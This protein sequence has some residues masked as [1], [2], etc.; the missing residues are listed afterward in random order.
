MGLGFGIIGCG[1]I[2]KFHAR[3][4]AEVRGAKLLACFDS[5]PA[6]ADRLAAETGCR[7]YHDL[8]AMLADPAI[9]G[10]D[11]RHPQRRPY[12]TGRCG[13]SGGQAR[14]CR[15]ARSRSRWRAAT[16]SSKLVGRRT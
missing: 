3:A 8:D 11:D 14:H 4:I 2:A 16:R 10:R 1:M 9:D 6:A 13:S 7:A 15:K 5:F 12:G